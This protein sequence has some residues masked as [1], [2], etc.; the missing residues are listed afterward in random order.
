MSG[1]PSGSAGPPR[2]FVYG[3]LAPGRPN[4]HVLANV[5]GTWEPATITGHLV[6]EGWGSSLGYPALVL[7]HEKAAV[8]PGMLLTSDA[9]EE[10]W[11]RLDLFEGPGYER[12]T[13]TVSLDDGT[14]RSAQTYVL[15]TGPE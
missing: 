15:R 7:E 5:T 11:E 10:E 1:Q 9:L 13:V 6:Q 4:E 14:Q 12:V 8:V 3:S 2:L